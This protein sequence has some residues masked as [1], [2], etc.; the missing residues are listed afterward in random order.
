MQLTPIKSVIYL[1]S[2]Q[3]IPVY[4]QAVRGVKWLYAKDPSEFRDI[5]SQQVG[6]IIV[7]VRADF[8]RLRTVE[9]LSQWAQSHPRL[10]FI[11]VIQAIEKSAYQISLNQPKW[12]FVYESEGKRIT[13][14]I[15]R[16]IQGQTVKSRRQERTPVKAP[17]MLKKTMAA[18]GSP[19]EGKVQFLKE[20]EM[21]DFSQGGAKVTL[22]VSGIKVKDFVSLMYKNSAGHWVSIESQVR[23]V[24]S[25]ASGKQIMG[26]QFLAVSA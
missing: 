15:T 1:S 8:L 24:V 19:I 14:V 22:D 16:R 9:T 4:L 17:V 10:S 5:L 2:S 21:N 13:D 11:F 7:I 18:D 20:G 3:V 12:L 25:T 23:W 26:V 6:D